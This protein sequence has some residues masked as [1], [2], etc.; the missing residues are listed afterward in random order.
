LI[1][2]TSLHAKALKNSPLTIVQHSLDL[3][4]RD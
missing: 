2:N 3:H 4:K 1:Y